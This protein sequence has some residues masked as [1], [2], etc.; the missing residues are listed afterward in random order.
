MQR[1]AQ[2]VVLITGMTM[3]LLAT[4]MAAAQSITLTD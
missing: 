2:H 3:I 1:Q 4:V